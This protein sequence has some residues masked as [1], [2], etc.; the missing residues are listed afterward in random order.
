MYHLS[1]LFWK[2]LEILMLDEDQ[3]QELQDMV[4]MRR[5]CEYCHE[6]RGEEGVNWSNILMYAQRAIYTRDPQTLDTRIL[7]LYP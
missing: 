3:L 7:P 4:K 1:A 6:W 5:I 2:L